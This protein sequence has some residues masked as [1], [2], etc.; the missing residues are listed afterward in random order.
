MLA[1]CLVN[2][3]HLFAAQS[4]LAQAAH[5]IAA[6]LCGMVV[7]GCVIDANAKETNRGR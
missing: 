3:Y 5:G 4:V 7:V 2:V 1:G 6:V